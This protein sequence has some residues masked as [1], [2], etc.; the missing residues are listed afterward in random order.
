MGNWEY[1]ILGGFLPP[2]PHFP[3]DGDWAERGRPSL[4]GGQRLAAV[5]V[6]R[7]RRVTMGRLEFCTPHEAWGGEA[8]AFTPLLAENGML[9]YLGEATGIG[10]LTLIE[11]EHS[12]AGNRSLDILTET[13]DGRRVA[14]ENQYNTAD[15]DHLT[16]PGP[17]GCHGKP[18]PGRD[19]RESS[20]RIHQCRRVLERD[21]LGQP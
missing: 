14:I 11:R 12:T 1:G 2:V 21:R 17:R 5:V 15:H 7:T 20:R 8:S 4:S 16:R 6:V 9:E 3:A 13:V 10:P 18:G 19:R